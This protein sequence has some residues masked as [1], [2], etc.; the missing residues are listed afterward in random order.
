MAIL[1]PHQQRVVDERDELGKRLEKLLKFI[2]TEQY[3]GLPEL[4]RALLI[5]QMHHMTA[6]HGVL[7]TRIYLWL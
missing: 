2:G 5:A 6:Y 4:E 1:Q 7:N 3:S